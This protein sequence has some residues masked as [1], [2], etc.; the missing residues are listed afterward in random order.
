MRELISSRHKLEEAELGLGST[1]TARESLKL[2]NYRPDGALR[3][4]SF[5]N[6]KQH[7]RRNWKGLSKEED[8]TAKS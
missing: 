2:K 1:P 3:K 4:K 5:L 6:W 7:Q 8:K